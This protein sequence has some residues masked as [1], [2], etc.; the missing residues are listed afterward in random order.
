MNVTQ[1]VEGLER[2][3]VNIR[4]QRDY[5]NDLQALERVLVPLPSGKHIPIS[6]VAKIEHQE[7]AAGHQ[8]R[9]RPAHRLDLCRP[10]GYRCRHL[11]RERPE[12][13]C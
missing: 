5:R 4:Y 13:R 8:E 3:P 1:T 6:Q 12:D 9:E 10:Q 2:Y 7:R 11:C